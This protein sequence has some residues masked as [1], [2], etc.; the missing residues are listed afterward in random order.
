MSYN[1]CRGSLMRSRRFSAVIRLYLL[2]EE[3][4]ET[5]EGEVGEEEEG[6]VV[7][8]DNVVEE[9]DGEKDEDCHLSMSRRVNPFSC[10]RHL[11]E[12]KKG[13]VIDEC[14]DNKHG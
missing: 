1:S 8:E 3:E 11:M 10:R 12:W 14:F 5:T 6:E 2:S 9:V 7:G 4:S 13:C